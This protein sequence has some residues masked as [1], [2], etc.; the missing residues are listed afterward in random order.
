MTVVYHARS[1]VGYVIEVDGPV[2]KLN[3]LDYHRGLVAAQSQ[4]I[5]DVASLGTMLGIEL[6]EELLV[7]QIFN[8]KFSEPG[9][10]H[11]NLP[12]GRNTESQPLR[13][14]SGS[15]V[16]TIATSGKSTEFTSGS[17]HTPALGARAYPLVD[18][19]IGSILVGV[20]GKGSKVNIGFEKTTNLDVFV[21]MNN[22]IGR[23]VAVLGSTG[24]GKSCFTASILQQIVEMKKS[25]VIIF[26]VNGEYCN[27][28]KHHEEAGLI[29]VTKIGDGCRIPYF[30]LGREGLYR[31]LLP[32]E[33]S[34]RPALNFA[35]ENLPYAKFIGDGVAIEGY[36]VAC[37]FDDCR[38][39]METEA[40]EIIKKLRKMECRQI[41]GKWPPM[42][43]I[44]PLAAESYVLP[45]EGNSGKRNSYRYEHI[46]PMLNRLYS[47]LSDPIYTAA[48][49]FEG[50]AGNA[51]TLD[52]REESSQLIA[53][54]FLENDAQWRIHI[55]DLHAV[56]RDLFPILL[57]TILELLANEMF[58]RKQ[59]GKVPMLLVLEEAHHYLRKQR[60]SKDDDVDA[61]AYERL[62][63]EGRKF[64]VSLWLS[65][66]RPSEVSETVLSQCGNWFTFRLTNEQDMRAVSAASEWATK[67]QVSRISSLP[68]QEIFA[69]GSGLQVPMHLRAPTAEP[70]PKSEGAAFDEW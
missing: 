9:D 20:T 46:A 38:L 4:G 56:S 42:R 63:K 10:V 7:I 48:I 43:A 21:S 5:S 30:A 8:M 27:A 16:G 34:Q 36:D 14:L 29:K 50:G 1:P 70:K 61:P 25:R 52:M 51:P 47:I 64:G 12:K 37:L 18:H 39:D 40:K 24:H 54:Y 49:D 35:I 57:S 69:F 6:G 59:E 32:S 67:Q 13:Q 22:L 66:Q 55:V 19:E 11:D 28:L 23:H 15:V 31:M 53:E 68:V 62:A 2:V 41:Q 58:F 44:G 17:L 45:S 3:L 33:K 60:E 26:D 65:T